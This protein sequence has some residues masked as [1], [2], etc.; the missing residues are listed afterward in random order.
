M[1][2]TCKNNVVVQVVGTEFN[3]TTYA[4]DDNIKLLLVSGKLDIL[5]PNNKRVIKV[6]Q[7]EEVTIYDL[8]KLSRKKGVR[9]YITVLPGKRVC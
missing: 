4:N 6:Q 5:D 9:S 3:L 1:Y 7:N 2:I 8:S